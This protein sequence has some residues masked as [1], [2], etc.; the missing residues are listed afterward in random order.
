MWRRLVV[1]NRTFLSANTRQSRSIKQHSMR[2]RLPIHVHGFSW[3]VAVHVDAGSSDQHVGRQVRRHADH[4][5][6]GRCHDACAVLSDISQFAWSVEHYSVRQ[7]LPI[8]VHG[9]DGLR[10]MHSVVL[11]LQFDVEC[12]VR[13]HHAVWLAADQSSVWPNYYDAV[14]AVAIAAADHLEWPVSADA[15]ATDWPDAIE[16]PVRAADAVDAAAVY[17][18]TAACIDA[19]QHCDDLRSVCCGWRQAVHRGDGRAML[20]Q[21][22][23]R[24]VCKDVP[25]HA[26]DCRQFGRM[27][28]RVQEALRPAVRRLAGDVRLQP[29][30]Q[31]ARRQV[32]PRNRHQGRHWRRVFAWRQF[33]AC[34]RDV[35]GDAIQ[36]TSKQR[37]KARKQ[38][39]NE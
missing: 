3:I 11:C 31:C 24:G 8:H 26:C 25:E 14:S 10:A 16:R 6:A 12:A 19:V 38:R 39:N 18:V 13:Q 21:F 27:H 15:A 37:E 29:G 1:N 28:H 17:D 36:L 20:L 2:Q 4:S 9:C 23:R 35:V 7:W 30:W 22:A 33:G 5:N 34:G 32:R